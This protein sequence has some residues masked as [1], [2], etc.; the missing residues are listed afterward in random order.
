MRKYFLLIGFIILINIGAFWLLP[1]V[2]F[3]K[4]QIVHLALVGP[5][6]GEDQVHGEAMRN[7]VALCLDKIRAQGRL[8]DMEIALSIFNDR[9]DRRSALKIASQLTKE[10]KVL[11]VLGH[12]YRNSCGVAGTIY[13]KNGIPA[14]TAS[15]IADA[16]FFDN[17]WYFRVRSSN[18]FESRFVA[19]YITRGLGRMSASI[20]AD[21]SSYSDSLTRSFEKS[22]RERGILV[23]SKWVFDWEDKNLYERLKR[24]TAQI[25]AVEDP[26]V[27]YFA[28]HA[29]EALT[30]LSDLEFPEAPFTII[31]PESFSDPSFQ[32]KIK[33]YAKEKILPGYYSTGVHT[34]M[35][36][37]I[38]I[39]GLRA[40]EFRKDYVEKYHQ[41]PSWV[42]ASY[43]DAMLVAINAIEKGETTGRNVREDRRRVRDALNRFDQP[44]TAIQGVTGP[45]Y[46][47]AKG[48]VRKPPVLGVYSHQQLLPAPVQFQSL[49]THDQRPG[50]NMVGRADS[51]VDLEKPVMALTRVV[52]TGVDMLGVSNLDTIQGTFTADFLIGFRFRGTLDEKA[53]RFIN[54]GEPIH[55]QQP[56]LDA[57][58]GSDTIRAYR[59]K[60]DFRSPMDLRSFPFDRQTLTLSLRHETEPRERLIFV[61]DH[62]ILPRG[63]AETSRDQEIV[64]LLDGWRI[65]RISHRN[66]I[67]SVSNLTGKKPND[68]SRFSTAIRLDRVVSGYVLN[69]FLPM[70]FLLL[71]TFWVYLMPSEQIGNRLL[72][73]IT[74]P[75]VNTGYYLLF[76]PVVAR[77]Y[78]SLAYLTVYG[79]AGVVALISL[80]S[81]WLRVR[82]HVAAADRIQGGG[83]CFHM[84]AVVAMGLWLSYVYIN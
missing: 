53:I 7:G 32:E 67:Q 11:M 29:P 62:G 73:L 71:I 4:K 54:A 44:K 30:I 46:F 72:L 14:V 24:I 40:H 39:G 37:M 15:A 77:G 41:E 49:A 34:L 48:N 74:V 23:K 78:L 2:T 75:V 36:F 51:Q 27:I 9:E 84:T 6:S 60:A 21:T 16:T 45:I 83:K 58:V 19:E 70:A 66:D 10:N 38:E 81:Y 56:V 12:Y 20:V 47:D 64:N 42:A 17:D 50:L 57:R 82:G 65:S 61:H 33:A 25:R 28:T 3:H 5:M 76:F 18:G 80:L 31:G 22:A 63:L 43:Y 79:L 13:N 35:P 59:V 8:G 52:Y 26:G 55:L 68:F 69:I 1:Q